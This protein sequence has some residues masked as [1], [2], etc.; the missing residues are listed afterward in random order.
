MSRIVLENR[1]V[2]NVDDWA[3]IDAP[4]DVMQRD[5][6]RQQLSRPCKPKRM[7]HAVHSPQTRQR[8]HVKVYEAFLGGVDDVLRQHLI[9]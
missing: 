5:A 2:E 3:C 7:H 9:V 4:I 6:N 8:A 1:H